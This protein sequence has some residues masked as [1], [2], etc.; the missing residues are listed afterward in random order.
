MNMESRNSSDFNAPW[1]SDEEIK[2]LADST[3]FTEEQLRKLFE[4]SKF[5]YTKEEL[6]RLVESAYVPSQ[7]KVV[8][9]DHEHDVI[10]YAAADDLNKP[11][12]SI[13]SKNSDSHIKQSSSTTGKIYNALRNSPEELEFTLPDMKDGFSYKGKETVDRPMQRIQDEIPPGYK[14]MTMWS[15]ELQDFCIATVPEKT[16]ELTSEEYVRY[17]SINPK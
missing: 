1:I 8:H 7:G 6:I 2:K 10:Y 15:H 16:P 4:A 17:S 11:E 5:Q 13:A 3:T 12:N 14:R 9:I